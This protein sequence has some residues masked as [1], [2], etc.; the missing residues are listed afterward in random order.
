M[1]QF[2]AGGGIVLIGCAVIVVLLMAH[3]R[4]PLCRCGREDC[5]GGCLLDA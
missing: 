3:S 1:W 5:G 2:I 4:A